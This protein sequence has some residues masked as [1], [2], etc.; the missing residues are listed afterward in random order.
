MCIRD[1]GNV[2][3]AWQLEQ[4]R[5]QRKG[6]GVFGPRNELLRGYAVSL[7][8]AGLFFALFG[9][10]GLVFFALQSLMAIVM[11]ETVNY[12]EHYGLRR[13]QLPNGKYERTTHRH[14]WNSNYLLTNMLLFQLQR[15]S[16]HHEFPAR[17]YQVLRHIDQSPQLPAGYATMM[18]LAWCPPLWRGVMD[19]RVQ[20]Y[21]EGEPPTGLPA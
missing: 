20:S 3:A 9:S 16:D 6:L 1:S 19:P 17:R 10:A 11:L 14:S 13:K 7:V 12:L 18:L 15:H 8:I 2:G 21:Y 4:E 5:L